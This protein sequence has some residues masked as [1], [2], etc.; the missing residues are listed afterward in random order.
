[1][2][3]LIQ[4]LLK[5]FI[6]LSIVWIF[7]QLVLRRLT[8][9]NANRWYLLGYTAVCFFIPF[10]NI[11]P[12]VNGS[13]GA[14][15]F[16]P[17]VQQY[18]FVLEESANCPAP[19][20][21]TGYDKWDWL[22]IA[23]AVGV[24][25]FLSKFIIRC[26]SFYKMRRQAKLVL[27]GEVR[28]YQ[29]D[30][31]IIPFSFGNSIFINQ[32]LHNQSELQ[33]IIRH[34]FVHVKQK[35][36][37]DIIWGEL[38]CIINWYNP[39]AWLIRNAIRQNLE[40]I[41][42]NKVLENGFDKKQYQY[43]LLKV[44]G[45][46]HFSIANQFNF[47][48]LKKRIA[49]MNKMK[50]ARSHLFKFVLLLPLVVVLLLA[51][52]TNRA[53]QDKKQSESTKPATSTNPKTA[54]TT[55]K[56]TGD[57]PD[58]VLWI[59]NTGDIKKIGDLEKLIGLD[60][61][62]NLYWSMVDGKG[63]TD[64]IPEELLNDKGYFI[65]IV[66]KKGE[67][68]VVVWDKN[69]KELERM[70]LT[71]WNE[72][73]EKYEKLYGEIL[74]AP[75]AP[76]Q[77]PV[78]PVPTSDMPAPP[79][80]PVK[81]K[82]K[83]G[84]SQ[85]PPPPLAPPM[86]DD[87]LA[88]P[89]PD[90]PVKMPEGVSGISVNNHSATVTLENGTVEKYNLDK[91]DEKKKFHDKYGEMPTPP[92]PPAAPKAIRIKPVKVTTVSTPMEIKVTPAIETISIKPVEITSL[93]LSTAVSPVN[94]KIN[95]PVESINIKPVAIDVKTTTT[96]VNLKLTPAVQTINIKPVVTNVKTTTIVDVKATATPTPLEEQ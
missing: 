38:L 39:F 28:L 6:S 19:V 44:I 5:L 82:G 17:T 46:R 42:D 2:S 33:E 23:L 9:Y 25:F 87:Y 78:P 95:S 94:L 22:F 1:M 93:K 10:I 63:W 79:Q 84:L 72:N 67:C 66:D 26:I 76:P 77:P 81:G 89:A 71:R 60:G 88:P 14:A 91:A 29:V 40:F 24:I 50:S 13:E 18:T 3:L 64:T 83:P 8:F 4:Y 85:P 75:P 86:P 80:P 21:S 31:D 51:F 56:Y 55:I 30:K 11:A 7:Y 70:P 15:R 49:M 47:S 20:L 52:R 12:V 45:N 59:S 92:E 41:A 90:A 27:S 16:I 61:S 57:F 43:L 35:H 69:K 54:Q 73:K 58:T 96:P 53:L 48:S 62:G 65:G 36:T 68:T 32:Q 74:A 37:H 34:E